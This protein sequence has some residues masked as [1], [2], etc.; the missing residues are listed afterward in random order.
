MRKMFTAYGKYYDLIY[1][2]KN[3]ERECNFLE[4]AFKRYSPFKP[5]TILDVGCGTG[6]HAFHLARRGYLVSGIDSS[7]VMI[8]IAREKT[9]KNRINVDFFLMDI[10]KLKLNKKFDTC[11]CMFAVMNYL[12]TNEEIGKALSGIRKHLKDNSLFI[13]DFWYGPTVLRV[14]PSLRTKTVEKDGVKVIRTAEPCL[15]VLRNT[16]NVTYHLIAIQG[17]VVVDEI[18]EKHVV[19]YF[20]PEEIRHCLEENGFKI[21]RLCPFPNLDAKIGAEDWNAAIISKAV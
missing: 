18:R 21:L 6:G 7:K 10:R 4:E 19:R 20:F 17:N 11:I 13:F 3:Y 8:D 2:D 16:C 12:T 14:L 5:R 15:N 1:S 9:E